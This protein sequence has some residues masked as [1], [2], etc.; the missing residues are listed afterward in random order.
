MRLTQVLKIRNKIKSAFE[1]DF[2]GCFF[3]TLNYF[4]V[5]RKKNLSI[6]YTQKKKASKEI[7]CTKVPKIV[8]V[9]E[10]SPT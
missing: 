7:Q 6:E 5:P 2:G 8:F 4:W 1:V 10:K 9:L 3:H